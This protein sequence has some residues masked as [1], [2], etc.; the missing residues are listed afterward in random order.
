MEPAPDARICNLFG[1]GRHIRPTAGNAGEHGAAHRD[2]GDIDASEYRLDDTGD[3]TGLN[4]VGAWVFRVHRRGENRL[5]SCLTIGV[6]VAIDI[7][8]A[9]GRDW[10]PEVVM[11]LGI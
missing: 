3:R 2:L 5:P 9:N 8:V 11:V 6:R 4:A 10:P 7:A 1:K